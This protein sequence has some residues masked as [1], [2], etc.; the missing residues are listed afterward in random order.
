MGIKKSSHMGKSWHLA[1]SALV[2]RFAR[3]KKF[4]PFNWNDGATTGL[5]VAVGVAAAIML[6]AAL[7][8]D[9]PAESVT[10]G[11]RSKTAAAPIRAANKT[12]T[13]ASKPLSETS[14][15]SKVSVQ[16]SPVTLTGCLEQD[17]DAFRLKDTTGENAPKSRSWK[18]GFLKKK[19]ASIEVVDPANRVQLP[20]HVGE[21]VVVTGML[22]DR[23]IQVRSLRRVAASCK[24]QA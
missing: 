7:Q 5:V 11:A 14:Q 12:G 21:R 8:S 2:K 10:A 20:S 19:A 9:K 16:Q 4:M 3:V 23:E 24:Q 6:S 1:Q 13:T 22:V 17:N 15:T 18:S